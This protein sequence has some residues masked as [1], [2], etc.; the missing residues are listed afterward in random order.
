MKLRLILLVVLTAV[1]ACAGP[2]FT[3]L[4][5][6]PALFG[7]AGSTV[8]WNFRIA[9]D[10]DFLLPLQVDYLT[11]NGVGTFTDLFSSSAPFL[12]PGDFADGSASYTIDLPAPPGGSD[13]TLELTYNL[14]DLDPNNPNFDPDANRI[15]AFLTLD[16]NQH[17]S[18]TVVATPEPAT[19]A[20]LGIGAGLLW[21]LF[22][23][24]S[25]SAEIP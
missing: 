13:G 15:G 25:H 24:R 14:Y 11:L 1:T 19:T 16:A 9:N 17:V 8:T 2:S 6:G 23:R 21:L 7:T 10:A 4:P 5:P 3:L 22:R 18:V 20:L 12:G